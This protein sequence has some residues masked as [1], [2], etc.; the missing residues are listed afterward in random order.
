MLYS[1]TITSAVRNACARSSGTAV[2]S[3]STPF[4]GGPSSWTGC[5]GQAIMTT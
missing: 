2:V 1:A 5:A 4:S 3:H